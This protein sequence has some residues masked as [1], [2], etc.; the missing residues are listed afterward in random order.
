MDDKGNN[1]KPWSH[2]VRNLFLRAWNWLDYQGSPPVRWTTTTSWVVIA[3]LLIWYALWALQ[4]LGED[5]TISH[6]EFLQATIAGLG[7]LGLG[8]NAF[9]TFKRANAIEEQVRISER[10]LKT[11]DDAQITERF[12]RA[13]E[14]LGSPEPQ[15]KIGGI[16]ALERIAK[17]Y[18]EDYHQ[19]VMEVLTSFIRGFER[20][21]PTQ[22]ADPGGS[23]QQEEKDREWLDEAAKVPRDLQ[24]AVTVVCRRDI[25]WEKQELQG[26]RLDLCGADLHHLRMYKANLT[27]ASLHS[28][29]LTGADL[30]EAN[31]SKAN[32]NSANL[33]GTYMYK[34]NL[35]GS[36]MAKANLTD[37]ELS[38]TNL[39]NAH[40]YEATMF[41][42]LLVEAD[43][44]RANMFGANLTRSNLTRACLVEANLSLTNLTYAGLFNTSLRQARLTKANLQNAR[45]KEADLDGADL[46]GADLTGAD[47]SMVYN[48]TVHQVRTAVFSK[49]TRL[50]DDIRSELDAENKAD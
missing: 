4:Y 44:T 6:L 37:A 8:A 33:S 34:S 32:L 13:I 19:T 48:L 3:L 41:R 36:L 9:Y 47:L 40:L 42:T 31:L 18:K 28:A 30:T 35:S 45:L 5:S 10:Q 2:A 39:S 29:N 17:D 50:P 12:S 27:R 16:Y 25:V 23:V 26:F 20:P 7:L 24:A 22:S 15:I 11:A 21:I 38:N 43:L 14:H 1:T 49:A 46:T